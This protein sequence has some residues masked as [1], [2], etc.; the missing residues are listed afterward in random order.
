[1]LVLELLK[2]KGGTIS[3]LGGFQPIY[4]IKFHKRNL[5]AGV[6]VT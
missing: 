6:G 5:Y 3:G 2:S 1:M 4:K